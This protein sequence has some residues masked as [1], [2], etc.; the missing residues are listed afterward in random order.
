M[1]PAAGGNSQWTPPMRSVTSS[2]AQHSAPW[3]T[4]LTG[5][6]RVLNAD[7]AVQDTLDRVTRLAA[8]ILNVPMA[9]L[10]VAEGERLVFRSRVGFDSAEMPLR[11]TFCKLTIAQNVPLVIPDAALDPRFSTN[12]MVAG[13][14]HIRFYAGL[15]ISNLAGRCIGT[16]CVLDQKTRDFDEMLRGQ[17]T[18]L[19]RTAEDL[20]RLVELQSVSERLLYQAKTESVRFQATFEQSVIGIA[21]VSE[22][23]EWLRVNRQLCTML[24]Y[25][26]AELRSL[27][28]QDLTHPEDLTKDL[29][30]H[31]RTL[32]GEIPG[33]SME[34]RYFRKDGTEL[35]VELTV[36]VVRKEDGRIDFLV[37]VIE[38]ISRRKEAEMALRRSQDTLKNDVAARTAAIERSNRNL[39][40]LMQR[41]AESAEK[42]RRSEEQMRL[43]IDGVPGRIAYWGADRRCAYCNT[44][45]AEWMGI[46][47][48]Y[49]VIGK[50]IDE[51]L[52]A[53]LYSS[54]KINI[55]YALAGEEQHFER[56]VV[57]DDGSTCYIQVAYFPDFDG[58]K[59]R[60]FLT[61]AVD[62]TE[63]KLAQI[64]LQEANA[65]LERETITDHL[66]GLRNRRF[67][68]TR[69]LEAHAKLR[70]F[71][72]P[73]G[74]LLLDL[75]HFKR[76]NDVHGHDAGDTVLRALG[77][78]LAKKVRTDVEA[79]IRVGG[80]EFAVIFYGPVT[81][82]TAQMFGE[83]IRRLVEIEAIDIGNGQTV[84]VTVS[85]GLAISDPADSSW[86]DV[87][88]RAD[89]AL[90]Q[91][92]EAGRNRV[93]IAT[94]EAE[95]DLAPVSLQRAG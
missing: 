9:F 39:Q 46:G 34:K 35:W 55:E 31:Q 24:G 90:Y 54:A 21:H 26:E 91:A 28:F 51:T 47:D 14:P 89:R 4:A 63:L 81:A 84:S 38:D 40:T 1:P 58:D 22:R 25:S 5:A 20:L 7:A 82:E 36:S 65:K 79:A 13:E 50:T 68:S 30:L 86:D 66:T 62:V 75:D 42:R 93:V 87:Y 37:K 33:F 60:G 3:L 18:D 32:G 69:G 16:F 71:G 57:E 74:L 48:P 94:T 59:V 52:P 78:I 80:E 67:F 92:K 72:Q 61:F 29:D 41:F 2:Q 83:R 6:G 45:F 44:A 88:R 56:Q 10:A 43:V 64:E 27:T 53:A 11:D 77:A 23:G 85:A 95:R 70:R 76:I 8:G 15:Q 73:Y 17:F 12:P 19:G 49:D